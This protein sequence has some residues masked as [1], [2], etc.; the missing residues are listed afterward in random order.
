[1]IGFFGFS[2]SLLSLLATPTLSMTVP[3][4]PPHPTLLPPPMLTSTTPGTWAYDTMSRR[5]EADI[6]ARLEEENSEELATPEYANAALQIASLRK[7]IR[8]SAVIRPVQGVQDPDIADWD[9]L[10]SSLPP[11][12]TYLTA[13]WLTAEFY[14]YRRVLEGENV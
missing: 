3:S 2:L 6:L 1:M 11:S 4:T 12:T 14:V 9:S 13:P 7:E 8:E 10:V 5:I